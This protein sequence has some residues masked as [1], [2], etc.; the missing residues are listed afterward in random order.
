M[1]RAEGKSFLKMFEEL[2]GGMI[3]PTDP[4]KLHW[5]N[6]SYSGPYGVGSLDLD[7]TTTAI[8]VDTESFLKSRDIDA[9]LAGV[10]ELLKRVPTQQNLAL[11]VLNKLGEFVNETATVMKEGNKTQMAISVTSLFTAM[12]NLKDMIVPCG[13]RKETYDDKVNH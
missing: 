13:T 6:V 11:A 8:K 1:S 7:N 12:R 10:E 5:A 2:K 3:M 4:D 9:I